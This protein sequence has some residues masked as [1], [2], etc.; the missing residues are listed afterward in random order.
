[1]LIAGHDLDVEGSARAR[2]T[3]TKFT[4]K[5]CDST[6][7]DDDRRLD[8]QFARACYCNRAPVFWRA[9]VGTTMSSGD[10]AAAVATDGDN[11]DHDDDARCKLARTRLD[12]GSE[13]SC[14]RRRV[15]VATPTA[16]TAAAA[17]RRQA[18]G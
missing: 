5:T 15:A 17:A 13:S 18:G 6:R 16:A 4:A 9:H 10:R 2:S 1:M 7:L 8:H 11:D 14:R 3:T 12:R